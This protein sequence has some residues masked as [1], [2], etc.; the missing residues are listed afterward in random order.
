MT[1]YLTSIKQR[2]VTMESKKERKILVEKLTHIHS[3]TAEFSTSGDAYSK[4]MDRLLIFSKNNELKVV[5]ILYLILSGFPNLKRYVKR[6]A[7][8][9]FINDYKAKLDSFGIE[10]DYENIELD[11]NEQKVIDL[12]RDI[13][14]ERK[15]RIVEFVNSNLCTTTQK[16]DI[17]KSRILIELI[18]QVKSSFNS[19]TYSLDDSEYGISDDEFSDTLEALDHEKRILLFRSIQALGN[20]LISNEVVNFFRNKIITSG[21]EE[22]DLDSFVLSDEDKVIEKLTIG[23]TGLKIAQSRDVASK[24]KNKR[25]NNF[26]GIAGS[27][28][29]IIFTAIIGGL[30]LAFLIAQ[31]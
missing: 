25:N 11:K 8:R 26:D 14:I 15:V 22:K 4:C 29:S 9:D 1:L 28:S 30:G 2:V 24:K 18:R 13:N 27:P 6:Q 21:V 3:A 10:I 16:S 20:G 31:K 12:F 7:F 17:P 23:E 5:K 19:S